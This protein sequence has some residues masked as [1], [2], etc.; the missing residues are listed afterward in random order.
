M[1]FQ[2]TSGPPR[3]NSENS[4]FKNSSDAF[5]TAP[6]DLYTLDSLPVVYL[7]PLS[8]APS[9]AA[10]RYNIGI[11]APRQVRGFMY[12]WGDKVKH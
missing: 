4:T 9:L 5:Q 11:Y 10:A 1:G 12:V 8:A 7:N 6:K 3:R 2:A